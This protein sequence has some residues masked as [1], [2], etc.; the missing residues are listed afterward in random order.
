MLFVLKNIGNYKIVNGTLK[1]YIPKDGTSAVITQEVTVIGKKAFQGRKKLTSVVIPDTVTE[2]GESAFSGCTK[3]AEINLPDSVTRLGAEAYR[4]IS[5]KWNAE[6]AGSRLIRFCETLFNG[7]R[8]AFYDDDGPLSRAPFLRGPG[9]IRT[10]REHT[11]QD[12]GS[13]L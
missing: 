10:L 8:A 6:E 1:K 2:I 7:G 12:H 5:D 11:R 3:L 13:G 9:F 4:T